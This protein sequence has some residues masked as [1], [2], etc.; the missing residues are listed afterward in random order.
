MIEATAEI[1]H[2]IDNGGIENQWDDLKRPRDKQCR[3]VERP[4]TV[5]LVRPVTVDNLDLP[6]HILAHMDGGEQVV[7]KC[8]EKQEVA[9]FPQRLLIERRVPIK[10]TKGNTK[11]EREKDLEELRPPVA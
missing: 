8:H 2:E 9:P 4:C 3:K 11:E 7:L 10:D 6:W 1:S 5:E